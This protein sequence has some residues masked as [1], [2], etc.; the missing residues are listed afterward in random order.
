M[1]MRI[2]VFTSLLYNTSGIGRSV[3]FISRP[4]VQGEVHVALLVDLHGLLQIDQ[5]QRHVLFGSILRHA[6]KVRAFY[7]VTSGQQCA[8]GLQC[9]H[10]QLAIV[11]QGTRLP[12][13]CRPTDHRR[14]R[15]HG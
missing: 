4:G 3:P 6:M 14:I 11:Y 1:I 7:P 8:A 15:P 12:A 13:L 9:Y 2:A 10:R 5:S